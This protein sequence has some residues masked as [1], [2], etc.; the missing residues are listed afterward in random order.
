MYA[1][2]LYVCRTSFHVR[3]AETE[4]CPTN[5]LRSRHRNRISEL[6]LLAQAVS[7]V[8]L[9]VKRDRPQSQWLNDVEATGP[10]VLSRDVDVLRKLFGEHQS[11][12]CL[13]GG[14]RSLGRENGPDE[15]MQLLQGRASMMKVFLTSPFCPDSLLLNQ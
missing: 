1:T 5:N 14:P 2:L 6:F 11:R 4:D 9:A 3:T 12:P 8:Y 15:H 7:R 10:G 13:Q